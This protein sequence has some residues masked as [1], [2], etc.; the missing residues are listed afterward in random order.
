MKTIIR[1]LLLG[2]LL[3]PMCAFA[4]NA[5]E[6]RN[7]QMRVEWEDLDEY[8]E[9]ISYNVP[10]YYDNDNNV[11]KHGSVRINYKKD[12][13]AR[14]GQKCIIAYS[15][16]GNYV[17]GKLNGVLSVE[18]GITLA[19]GSLKTKG[20]LSFANG[21]PVGTWT[22]SEIAS[23]GNKSETRTCSITIKDDLLVSYNDGED[24]FKLN[25]DGTFS[26][27][28]NGNVYKKS[29]NTSKFVRK[30]GERTK[31]DETAQSM[32]NALIAGTMSE[33]DLITK[34]FGLERYNRW[35]Y[36]SINFDNLRFCFNKLDI[37]EFSDDGMPAKEYSGNT[38]DKIIKSTE[39][40]LENTYIYTLR[41]ANI[42][43]AEELIAKASAL[44]NAQEVTESTDKIVWR[45]NNDIYYRYEYNTNQIY[46]SNDIYDFTDEAKLKLEE[47]IKTGLEERR[48]EQERSAEEKRLEQERIAEEKRLEQERIAEEKRL[49]EI[50]KQIRQFQPICDYLVAQKSSTNISYDSQ[51]DRY[52]DSTGLGEYWRL[53]LGKAIKPFCKIV[54]CKLVSYENQ[55]DANVA[56]LDITKFNKKG[57]ITYRVPVTIVN[58]RI[59]VKSIDFSSATIIEGTN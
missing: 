54:D 45:D 32:I 2:L 20:T 55:G 31:P 38:L 48:L 43:S 30:T 58:G 23:Q 53:D 56:V 7:E 59:L 15:V 21:V 12:L 33:S 1:A 26:G 22:F 51:A 11:I 16:S 49:Q 17:N 57:N 40:K 29:I 10:I 5:T 9:W 25:D 47:A 27:V 41:R 14:V 42:I 13:T 8:G 3:T 52:F 39:E 34:G 4:Q 28:L 36:N 46:I 24:N 18:E 44:K 35:I 37:G 50:E 6:Q 19:A